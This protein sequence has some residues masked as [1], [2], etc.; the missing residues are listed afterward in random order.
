MLRRF[1]DTYRSGSYKEFFSFVRIRPQKVLTLWKCAEFAQ[2]KVLVQKFINI[3][4]PA[5][6]EMRKFAMEVSKFQ[7]F[8]T[9]S[10][11]KP[12]RYSP[13]EEVEHKEYCDM[14]DE[15]PLMEENRTKEPTMIYVPKTSEELKGDDLYSEMLRALASP[16]NL[17]GVSAPESEIRSLT[18]AQKL[19]RMRARVSANSGYRGDA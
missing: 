2:D 9:W 12:I 14:L 13:E 10:D 1:I 3:Y 11:A 15:E 4:P 17:G 18:G 16:P 8:F 19:E 6:Q 7:C 5:K